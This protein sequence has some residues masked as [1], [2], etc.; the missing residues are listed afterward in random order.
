MN[1]VICKPEEFLAAAKVVAEV[2]PYVYGDSPEVLAQRAMDQT[3]GWYMRDTGGKEGYWSSYGF[4]V[5]VFRPDWDRDNL[6]CKVSVCPH[7]VQGYID[8]I[9]DKGGSAQC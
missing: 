5:T 6:H 7:V 9:N 1:M 2:N 4:V 8:R 3:K